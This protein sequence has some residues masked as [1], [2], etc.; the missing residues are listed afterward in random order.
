MRKIVLGPEK[1]HEASKLR[2]NRP[3][4]TLPEVLKTFLKT[5]EHEASPKLVSVQF[6]SSVSN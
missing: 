2:M 4:Q 1:A 5:P 3:P 6:Y